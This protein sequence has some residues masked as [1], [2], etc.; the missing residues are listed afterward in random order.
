VGLGLVDLEEGS[1][2]CRSEKT[3]S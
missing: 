2:T 1:T 3:S